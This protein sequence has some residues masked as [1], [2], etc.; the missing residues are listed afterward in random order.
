M[1]LKRIKL[2]I[3]FAV[4]FDKVKLKLFTRDININVI[5]KKICVNEGE[6]KGFLIIF[7][8]WHCSK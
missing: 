1:K 8:V 7:F 4:G 5:D 3:F 6:F 2:S